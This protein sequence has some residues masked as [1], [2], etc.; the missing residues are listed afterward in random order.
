MDEY[1]RQ[2]K[3]NR[4]F[5]YHTEITG[6]SRQ[7][8]VNAVQLSPWSG[9]EKNMHAEMPKMETQKLALFSLITIYMASNGDLQTRVCQSR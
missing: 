6:E 4:S 1:R 7:N 3:L 5:V 8:D 9:R 2:V